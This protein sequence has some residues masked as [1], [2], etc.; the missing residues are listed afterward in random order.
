MTESEGEI[1]P[2]SS[3]GPAQVEVGMDVTS[4]DGERVGR[5]KQVRQDRFLL[6]RP[7]AHDLW[8][9]FS[10]V[11]ATQDYTGKFRGG[12]VEPTEVVLNVSEAHIDSQGWERA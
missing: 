1:L 6:D 12:P 9:P 10:S 11:M 2:A 4:I 5:V 8:V 7:L 3:P